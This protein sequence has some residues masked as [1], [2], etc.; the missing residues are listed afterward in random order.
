MTRAVGQQDD[1]WQEPLESDIAGIAP[2]DVRDKHE[3]ALQ[4]FALPTFIE[5]PAVNVRATRE[6]GSAC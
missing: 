1:H 2:M 6:R 3:R 4:G 5:R